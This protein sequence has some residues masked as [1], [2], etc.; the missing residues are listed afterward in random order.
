MKFYTFVHILKSCNVTN[1]NYFPFFPPHLLL[2]R[3]WMRSKYHSTWSYIFQEF[4][5]KNNRKFSK[6]SGGY[7]LIGGYTE[8]SNHGKL[9]YFNQRDFNSEGQFQ[10]KKPKHSV[11]PTD[12]KMSAKKTYSFQIKWNAGKVF[13][14]IV[15]VLPTLSNVPFPGPGFK[16]KL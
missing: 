12:E 15:N 6:F 11:I 16:K 9:N 14:I 13:T 2:S 8:L 5:F 7:L 3:L 10:L 4:L 1:G